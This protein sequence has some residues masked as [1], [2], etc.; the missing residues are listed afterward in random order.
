[1]CGSDLNQPRHVN[2][3]PPVLTPLIGESSGSL[4]PRVVVLM[5]TYNGARFV[6]SQLESILAQL[7]VGGRVFIRDDGSSDQTVREVE[8]LNDPRIQHWLG[9]NIGF[10][11]SFLALLQR[12]PDEVD[13]VMFSDQDD[14]WLHG[15]IARAWQA[16]SEAPSGP[17]LYGCAQALVDEDLRPLGRS[18]PPSNPPSLA[19]ALTENI[20]VGCTAAMNRSAASLLK[21]AGVPAGIKFHD[22][23][24]YLVVSTFGAVIYDDQPMLL[25]RQH[26]HNVVGRHPGVR[27]TL[28]RAFKLIVR[29]DW[30]GDLLAQVH[31][32]LLCFGERMDPQKREWIMRHFSSRSSTVTPRWRFVL[33]V[34]RWH[35]TLL[36]ETVLRGLI[37]LEKLGAR[38]RRS[39]SADEY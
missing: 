2:I 1:M 15:K 17:T 16:L 29:G 6:K 20:I 39:K 8:S 35:Q 24:T 31:S 12:V 10:G 38:P 25:Y 26:G 5:S 22:W 28:Q 7:P 18:K 30:I 19:N 34:H 9:P 36:G 14:I 27:A 33:C 32:L 21:S 13:M 37:V 11:A 23:W 3:C 4:K